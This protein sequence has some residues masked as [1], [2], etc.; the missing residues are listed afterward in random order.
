M[1]ELRL[2]G[3]GS[4]RPAGFGVS[5]RLALPLKQ[6]TTPCQLL[7]E[8]GLARTPD[9]ILL[10]D[11]TAVSPEQWRQPIIH[12]SSEVTLLSAVEGG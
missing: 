6:P 5:G 2:I 3:F 8:I 10:V 9:L 11:S 1:A 12:D 4:D 7:Q